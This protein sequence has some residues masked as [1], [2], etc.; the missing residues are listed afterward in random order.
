MTDFDKRD[1]HKNPLIQLA[2]KIDWRESKQKDRYH[3]TS[4]SSRK[5]LSIDQLT[6]DQTKVF[7]ET[8]C[9]TV[10]SNV[11]YTCTYAEEG[12]GYR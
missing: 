3:H 1:K 5:S 9:A 6:V 2:Y 4:K 12:G 7:Y 11:W 10:S 8:A